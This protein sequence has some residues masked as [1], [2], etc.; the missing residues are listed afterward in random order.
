MKNCKRSTDRRTPG[1][2][3]LSRC[4]Y[5][6][7][8]QSE[9]GWLGLPSWCS[10]TTT[11]LMSTS[12]NTYGGDDVVSW[13]TTKTTRGMNE[14]VT[15]SD[16]AQTTRFRWRGLNIRLIPAVD[17]RPHLIYNPRLT[18]PLTLHNRSATNT[19]A[20]ISFTRNPRHISDVTVQTFFAAVLW[21]A[22][23]YNDRLIRRAYNFVFARHSQL[24][25]RLWKWSA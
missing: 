8:W 21:F 19:A 16:V 6:Y 9:S 3:M 25:V 20:E 2:P 1:F 7:Y 22:W 18:P 11:T 15:T 24:H 10:S 4:N 5:L 17:T 23:L 14:A 13:S 12:A